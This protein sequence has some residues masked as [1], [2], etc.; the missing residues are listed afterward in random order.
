MLY[1]FSKTAMLYPT[2]LSANQYIRMIL[3]LLFS[4]HLAEHTVLSGQVPGDLAMVCQESTQCLELFHFKRMCGFFFFFACTGTFIWLTPKLCERH[5]LLVIWNFTK[6]QWLET[7]MN[8][9]IKEEYTLME[10]ISLLD[11][12]LVTELLLTRWWYKVQNKILFT[13]F[14]NAVITKYLTVKQ[15]DHSLYL[16]IVFP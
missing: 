10:G 8:I 12:F 7:A 4:L 9:A 14:V 16:I 3:F 13:T 6:I 15:Y 2:Q 1:I 5:N 11:H